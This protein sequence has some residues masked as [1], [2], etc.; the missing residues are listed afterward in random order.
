MI[1]N[2]LFK[3]EVNTMRGRRR[4]RHS[5]LIEA[6]LTGDGRYASG[7]S[8]ATFSSTNGINPL[9]ERGESPGCSERP[10]RDRPGKEFWSLRGIS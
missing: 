3:F 6:W 5:L 8:K 9:S 10:D 7:S 4:R 2:V 1:R